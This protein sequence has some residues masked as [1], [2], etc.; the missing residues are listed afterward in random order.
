MSARVLGLLWSSFAIA[1]IIGLTVAPSL[2]Q[3]NLSAADKVA[4]KAYA[5]DPAKVTG[6]IAALDALAMAKSSDPAIGTEYQQMEREPDESITQARAKLARHPRIF[7][8]YQRQNLT[9]DDT[10]LI[11][12]VLMAAGLAVA[13]PGRMADAV[14]GAQMNFVRSNAALIERLERANVSLEG[15]R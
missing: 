9:A 6:Y 10:V 2:A 11:P 1:V 12:F 13:V 8:F 4:M 14:T 15:S 3:I 7:A 5:L